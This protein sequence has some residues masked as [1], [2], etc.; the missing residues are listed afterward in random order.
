MEQDSTWNIKW[1]E[2]FAGEEDSQTCSGNGK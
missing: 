1:Q 2:T